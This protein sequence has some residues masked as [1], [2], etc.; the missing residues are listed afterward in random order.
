MAHRIIE[1]IDDHTLALSSISGSHGDLCDVHRD[2]LEAAE[3]GHEYIQAASLVDRLSVLLNQFP[4]ADPRTVD[5]VITHIVLGL[6]RGPLR[7]L[8]AGRRFAEASGWVDHLWMQK[9]AAD[10][11]IS[12]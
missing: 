12:A 8:D 1:L 5:L 7:P 3:R 11:E 4:A 6:R 2:L 10:R 9:R